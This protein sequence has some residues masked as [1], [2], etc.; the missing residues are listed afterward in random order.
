MDAENIQNIMISGVSSVLQ[1]G[2]LL[3]IGTLSSDRFSGSPMAN[4]DGPIISWSGFLDFMSL[5]DRLGPKPLFIG[6]F[7][8]F[9]LLG[10]CVAI[11]SRGDWRSLGGWL[12]RL[13]LLAM[14]AGLGLLPW[15]L[16]MVGVAIA[17][18]PISFLAAAMP[19]VIPPV[20]SF[21]KPH[22]TE[23]A[24]V[25][26]ITVSAVTLWRFFRLKA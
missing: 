5:M 1:Q 26:S 9:T 18:I 16:G 21:L 3:H 10:F 20:W 11:F 13:Q 22:L 7:A 6:C 15:V 2:A 14:F 4:E 8:V 23:I 19:A 24:T 17:Y 12:S 25:L